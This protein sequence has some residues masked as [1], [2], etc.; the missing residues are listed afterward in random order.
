M[1]YSRRIEPRVI[2]CVFHS[3][4]YTFDVDLGEE[5]FSD[6][7]IFFT[8]RLDDVIGLTSLRIYAAATTG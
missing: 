5:R 8:F 1:S 4:Y 7:G 3:F 2:A 6:V